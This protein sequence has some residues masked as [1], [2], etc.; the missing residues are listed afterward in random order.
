VCARAVPAC[1]VRKCG[2]GARRESG[3]RHGCG[4]AVTGAVGGRSP[5][6]GPPSQWMAPDKS[7]G[8]HRFGT[9][10][11]MRTFFCILETIGIFFGCRE[12]MWSIKLLWR[13]SKR[14]PAA[15]D[16]FCAFGPDTTAFCAFGPDTTAVP[17]LQPPAVTGYSEYYWPPGHE[18]LT[19]RHEG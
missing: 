19:F 2:V 12:T 5:L 1:G 18:T 6:V 16:N 11:P 15:C 8:D 14:S 17:I 13:P 9:F 3:Q 4:E 10:R 7:R